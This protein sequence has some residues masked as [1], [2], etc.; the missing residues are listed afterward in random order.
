M[1]EIVDTD[2]T[3]TINYYQYIQSELTMEYGYGPSGALT[4]E[5][6]RIYG[7]S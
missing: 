7:L 4:Q 3:L 6:L 5:G 1:K 2:Y